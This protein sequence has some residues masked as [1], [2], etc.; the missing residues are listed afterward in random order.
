MY[1]YIFK[2]IF[3]RTFSFII[4]IMLSPI[5]LIVSIINLF[6]NG[7]PIL[8]SQER[9]GKNK[10]IFRMYKFRSMSNKKDEQGL[11]LPDEE[12]LTKF[13][14]FLR[15]TSIDELPSLLNILKGD[16]S[17]IGP[18]PLL[19]KYLPYYTS[20][21]QIRHTVKPGLTGLAQINGRNLLSWDKR[22]ELDVKYV[23]NMTLRNDLKIIFYTL[24]KVIKREDIVVGNDHIMEDFDVERKNKI[25]T[26]DVKNV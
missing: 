23:E 4:I 12:R 19:V 18:R 25:K 6:V 7:R 8:F 9:P 14:L 16:M 21:E 26:G 13:G 3:D 15:K 5:L 11:L 1:K 2:N 22:L 24:K 10:R 20:K 17:F